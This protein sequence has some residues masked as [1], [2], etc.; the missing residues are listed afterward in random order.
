MDALSGAAVDPA[1]DAGTLE[2][3]LA[4]VD[5]DDARV[6]QLLDRLTDIGSRAQAG[7]PAPA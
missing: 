3:E 6:G 2:A 5:R 7:E 1:S 4:A